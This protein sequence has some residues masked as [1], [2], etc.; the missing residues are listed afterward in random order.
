[1][2][3]HVKHAYSCQTMLSLAVRDLTGT[4]YTYIVCIWK[5]NTRGLISNDR[6]DPNL[7]KMYSPLVWSWCSRLRTRWI[8]HFTDC[9]SV[10]ILS[11]SDN[12][13]EQTSLYY[14]TIWLYLGWL[15][16]K[17]KQKIHV[18]LKFSKQFFSSSCDCIS[19]FRDVDG[20]E[21][22]FCCE[23]FEYRALAR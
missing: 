10:I 18:S 17:T 2:V 9:P 19:L 5:E 3:V 4:D 15:S 23:L 11:Q 22:G 13:H 14:H 1:M 6:S 12:F 8:L 16:V 20:R 21:T 7:Y